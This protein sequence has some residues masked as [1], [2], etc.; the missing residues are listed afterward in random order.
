[1]RGAYHRTYAGATCAQAVRKPDLPTIG[2]AIEVAAQTRRTEFAR[3]KSPK[4]PGGD[5]PPDA[6]RI[7]LQ[8]SGCGD[9]RAP[10]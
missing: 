5:P 2:E 9:S 1:M 4:S 8:K 6:T 7:A 10:Q 3:H